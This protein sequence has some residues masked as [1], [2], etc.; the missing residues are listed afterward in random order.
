MTKEEFVAKVA[1]D[2]GMPKARVNE[3]LKSIIDNIKKVLK[4]GDKITFI[5][6]GSFQVAKR[7]ARMGRN[8]QTGEK[9]KFPATKVPKFRPSRKLRDLIG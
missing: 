8:P 2:V 9:V 3:V 6:F 1:A 4:K 5:G 7:A